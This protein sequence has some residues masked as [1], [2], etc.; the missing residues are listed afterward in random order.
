MR[1]LSG[2]SYFLVVVTIV[3][4]IIALLPVLYMYVDAMFSE[5]RFSLSNYSVVLMDNRGVVLLLRSL[6]LAIA[7]TFFSILIGV[8]MAFLISRTDVPL[9]SLLK[10]A[11]LLPLFIPPY[12]NAIAWI[13][14][15][16]RKGAI[17]LLLMRLLHLQQPWFTIYGMGGAIFVLT[18]SY[19]PCIVLLTMGALDNMDSRL[20]EAGRLSSRMPSVLRRI[21]FPLAAPAVVSGALFT[22][23]F[24][25]AN[26]GVPSLLE[27]NVFPV[28]IFAQFSAFF[29]PRAA[30]AISLPLVI[31]TL[32]AVLVQRYYLRKKSYVTVS[33][34]AKDL[35]LVDLR[36]YVYP[37]FVFC[38]MVIFVS[39]ILPIST[40][41]VESTSL[42]TYKVAFKTGYKQ[43][44]NS[45]WFAAAGATVIVAL[46]FFL[47]CIIE[48]TRLRM[49]TWMD[50]ASVIPYAVPATI[51][52]IGLIRL[53]N[54]PGLSNA[55]YSTFIIVIL[56]YV[57]RFTPFSIRTISAGFKR[58]APSLEEAAAVAGVSW[59]RTLWKIAVPL[60]KPALYAGWILAFILC[61]GELG[62]TILVYPSGYDTL[63]I[64]IFTL[65]HYGPD[66]LVAALCVILVIIAM[67]P[68]A[69]FS[70]LTK[71][72]VRML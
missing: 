9:K 65:M 43:I 20:E 39:V 47:S 10:I 61:M 56:G 23:M 72:T 50:M 29:N 30:S 25:I 19:F 15:M 6:T 36:R 44:I 24:T 35:R 7:T 11:C 38:F 48:R 27:V 32:A 59:R 28:E 3:F 45:I 70:V 22:F 8:P 41:I 12:I 2:K 46:G 69:L 34:G 55:I 52:G 17:N 33:G 60:T 49:K 18:L 42:E 67:V 66:R 51:V 71:R 21:S 54:R 1:T 58:I 14:L 68:L 26:F 62:T 31:V 64:R 63:P 53:W 5:G 13:H 57:A 16:G 4:S 37:A 40:L